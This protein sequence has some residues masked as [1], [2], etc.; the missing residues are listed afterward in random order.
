M[1]QLIMT[2]LEVENK[3]LT[4]D[5]FIMIKHSVY[6]LCVLMKDLVKKFAYTTKICDIRYVSWGGISIINVLSVKS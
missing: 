4:V 1:H 3:Y 6:F 5:I 2:F